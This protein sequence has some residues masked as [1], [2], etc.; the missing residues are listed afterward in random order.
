MKPKIYFLLCLFSISTLAI[1]QYQKK[2][3]S[4]SEAFKNAK[5]DSTKL[6]LLH[7]MF[8]YSVHNDIK[9]AKQHVDN[10]LKLAKKVKSNTDIANAYYNLNRYFGKIGLRDSALIVLKFAK[11]KYIEADNKKGLANTNNSIA[12]LKLE[13]GYP[14]DALK[15]IEENKENRLFLKDS[16]GLAGDYNLKAGI[17]D[18]KGNYKL[19][20]ENVLKAIQIYELI[21]SP[22]GKAD[23]LYVLMALEAR[24]G[25]FEKAIEYGLEALSIFKKNNDEFYA[26]LC[27][28]GI[29]ECYLN[30]KDYREARTY[31]T[32]SIDIAIKLN[33]VDIEASAK[34]QLGN[35]FIETKSYNSGIKLLLESIEIKKKSNY[36]SS[37]LLSLN[38]V[39]KAYNAIE[40]PYKAI[41]YS[42]EVIKIADSIKSP[43]LLSSAFEIRSEAYKFL[44]DFERALNDYLVFNKIQDSLYNEAKSLQ[45][46][47]LRTEFDTERKE[48]EL[49]IEKGKVEILEKEAYINYQQR[50][51]LGG[52]LGLSLVALGFGF[53]GFRQKAKKSKLE[54]EKV[55]T[56]LAF[57]KKELTTHA[58]H[59]AKKNEVL[60]SVKL[61]AEAL[62][63]KG[64]AS[65]YQELI[66][67]INFDQQD[68]KN[69]ESFTQYF[70]QV[71][72]DFAINVKKK[73]PEV[74]KN[75]LRF[76]ALM[77]MSMSS[78]EIATIL[79]ISPDGIKKARQRLRKKMQLSPQ[80]S[81][82]HTV[83]G[84]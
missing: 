7:G 74:T 84:I 60:E 30:L 77:K 54:Q 21:N 25:N 78:K 65:G 70:E 66:K 59:L 34:E 76:M 23:A 67:T 64:G 39:G 13:Q 28:Y 16:A 1:A 22:I 73:Y 20:T 6:D 36:S 4:L 47:T 51:L 43:E 2:Y 79:N 62:K 61:K 57:K 44:G 33:A 37:L 75:E 53:Y 40:Q 48:K 46:N 45:I 52:G 35:L 68:D 69:W 15:I 9:L 41:K 8:T 71:H 56:E 81:L 29:G 10:Q 55:E 38:S 12:I 83:L 31:L 26:S 32:Q 58:L 3:D 50:L 18:H 72:K 82:E 14:D 17:Y 63:E 42:S 80:D 27:L 11:A 19:A 5:Q 49:A 24:E